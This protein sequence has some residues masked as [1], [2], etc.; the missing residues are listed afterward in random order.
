MIVDVVV[1]CPS[2]QPKM[3]IC[4]KYYHCSIWRIH[5]RCA[6]QDC[7]N[8]FRDMFATNC[9]HGGKLTINLYILCQASNIIR[10][11]IIPSVSH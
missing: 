7:L 2:I 4:M 9:V 11:A 5:A 8:I 6:N 1:S 3:E 10:H